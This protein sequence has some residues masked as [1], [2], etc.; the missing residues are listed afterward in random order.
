MKYLKSF[1]ALNESNRFLHMREVLDTLEELSFDFTDDG[2]E[3]SFGIMSSQTLH[4][5][6]FG[7]FDE[8]LDD[9]QIKMS[10]I[11]RSI[12]YFKLNLR[13]MKDQFSGKL[14][15]E[16][17]KVLTSTIKS[18]DEFLKSE[19]MVISG[20]WVKYILK[21]TKYEFKRFNNTEDLLRFIYECND[22]NNLNNYVVDVRVSF[23][24]QPLL[25]ESI[26]ISESDVDDIND[27][28][29]DFNSEYSDEGQYHIKADLSYGIKMRRGFSGTKSSVG[30]YVVVISD[31]TSSYDG[32]QFHECVPL[33][34][35]L[36]SKFEIDS[37]ELGILNIHE[38]GRKFKT[39][40]KD[41]LES[42]LD[43]NYVMDQVSNISISLEI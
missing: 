6:D 34:L 20:F 4:D 29:D 26:Q 15:D 37:I 2:F 40:T 17:I 13:N 31:R 27:I 3:T 9:I 12:I 42:Y 14:N 16:E 30:Q 36:M 22:V 21:R 10:S 8:N 23:M 43:K 38:P 32:F 5:P 19:E 11:G 7:S 33:V 41:Q 39:F 28:I 35:R 1:R 18:I 24:G 25:D